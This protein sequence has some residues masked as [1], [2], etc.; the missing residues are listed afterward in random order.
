MQS[1]LRVVLLQDGRSLNHVYGTAF[2][3]AEGLFLTAAH[4]IRNASEQGDVSL[5]YPEGTTWMGKPIGE[6]EL[7]SEYDVTLFKGEVPNSKPLEWEVNELAI[8][9]FTFG[10]E[11]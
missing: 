2:C 10:G 8:S 1:P 9:L 7:F 4:V 11:G 6:H 5:G 3:L